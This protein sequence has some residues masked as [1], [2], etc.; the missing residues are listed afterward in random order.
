MF[1]KHFFQKLEQSSIGQPPLSQVIARLL[2]V[3]RNTAYRKIRG[4]VGLSLEEFAKLSA[5]FQVDLNE[6]V[7]NVSQD[8]V[9]FSSPEKISSFSDL[10]NYFKRTIESLNVLTKDTKS[11]LYYSSRDLSLFFYF[12]YKHLAAFKLG[13]WL[14]EQQSDVFDQ[15]FPELP[16]NLLALSKELGELYLKLPTIELWTRRTLANT[17]EQINYYVSAGFINEKRGFDVL[18]DLE[19]VIRDRHER[20]FKRYKSPDLIK[21]D[22]YWCDFI[23]LP[24]AALAVSG[25]GNKA[26]VAVSGIRFMECIDQS[27]CRDLH[28]SFQKHI[29]MGKLISGASEK[30]RNTFFNILY[31]EIEKCRSQ[32]Y[33]II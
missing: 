22:L 21:G 5:H 15:N 2:N 17:L 16:E 14:R 26:F 1:Q 7:Y 12:R 31:Q 33:Q 24:N 11:E 27:F 18:D 4:E 3:N 30:D 10:E 8:N 20:A 28:H 6:L 13:L 23:M 25:S 32:L 19:Q 9:L 29:E